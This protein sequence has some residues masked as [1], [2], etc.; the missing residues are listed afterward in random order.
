[1]KIEPVYGM[2]SC[3]Y[4]FRSKPLRCLVFPKHCPRH[5]DECPVLPLY[6]TILL[7]RVGSG[8]LML[9]AFL[10]KILLHLKIL[11]FRSIV[12]SDLFHFELK[13]ILS[14]P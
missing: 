12:A 2:A 10:L 3:S 5:V 6:N 13:L 9:D 11:E 4:S 14:S 8:E 7:W 1:M